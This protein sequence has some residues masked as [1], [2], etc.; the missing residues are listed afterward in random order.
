ML[1]SIVFTGLIFLIAPPFAS[2]LSG[3][4]AVLFNHIM[5]AV[6]V[7]SVSV[8]PWAV[9]QI[10]I[11]FFVGSSKTKYNLFITFIRIYAF[12]LPCIIILTRFSALN[13]FSIW[14]GMLLS[15][16]L[17]AIFGSGTLSKYEEINTN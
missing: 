4:D 8:I 16:I 13:E 7:Y 17:T 10:V 9:F 11:G 2:I 3:K 6:H 5:D 1:F 12:R 14:Y 15:N